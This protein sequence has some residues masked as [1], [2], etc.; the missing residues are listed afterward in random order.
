MTVTHYL[1]IYN[2]DHK[3]LQYRIFKVYSMARGYAYA[4][5]SIQQSSCYTCYTEEVC[6]VN[7]GKTQHRARA[8]RTL[9]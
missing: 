4:S 1:A 7:N 5:C 6:F 8:T 3:I 2:M 9:Q